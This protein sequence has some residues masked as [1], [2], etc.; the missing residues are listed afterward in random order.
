[1]LSKVVLW[2]ILLFTISGV[3]YLS[4]FQP[5]PPAR[6]VEVTVESGLTGAQIAE[7]LEGAG[8]ISNQYTFRIYLALTQTE[9]GLQPGDYKFRT[10]FTYSEIV[11]ELTKPKKKL[12]VQVAIPEGFTAKQIAQRLSDKI[13][14]PVIDFNEYIRGQGV[15]AVRP[16]VLPPE[17]GLLEGY[18]FPKTYSFEPK[19]HPREVI[20][21][22]VD[23]FE[24]ETRDIDW[25]F[26]QEK[27]LTIHE[28]IT[29]A[30]LIETEAQVAEERPLVSAVIYNRLNIGMPLQIDATVQY[31]L[32][33]RKE[34]LTYE[35]LKIAS[36]YNTYQRTGLPPGPIASPGIDSIRAALAPAPVDY[37]YY[38][39]TSPDGAHTFTNN[40]EDFLRAKRNMPN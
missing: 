12:Y 30:S 35:D 5:A 38:V 32:P 1:V 24:R 29:V 22:M 36:P 33:E 26:A 3:L 20:R 39:L 14:R 37:L 10:D 18:L 17:V 16:Q 28:I 11:K 31:A 4:F 40:Y 9:S 25:S 34:A 19:E 7:K 13:D 23:Q 6:E 27:N 2:S 21:K 15:D 8:V